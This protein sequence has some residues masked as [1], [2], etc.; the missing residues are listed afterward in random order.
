MKVGFFHVGRGVTPHVEL[1]S[2]L[3]ASIRRIMPTVPIVHF[4]DTDTRAIAGVDE[5]WRQPSGP[6]ALGCLDAYADAGDED[7]LFV[8]TDVVIQRDVRHIFSAP[9]DIA[10]ADRAGT[11]KE[12]E[13]GTK[14]MA[15]MPYN[16]GAVFSRAPTFWAAAA[17]HLRMQSEKR[18]NW[19]GDQAS[20]NHVIA[21]GTF[22]V[23]ILPARYNYPPLR[24]D[25]DIT[26]QAILHY[27]GSRK[28]WMLESHRLVHR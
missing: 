16:K 10:V 11:L 2:I 28:A 21:A 24:Q 14:F 25:E 19:M 13:I 4:T 9:F 27:K 8:D 22:K 18:Q 26:A 15:S 5:V 1:A 7:W 17:A 3:I 20:M 23:E 6:I 12:K